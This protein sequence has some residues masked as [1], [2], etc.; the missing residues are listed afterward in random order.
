MRVWYNRT[1]SSVYAAIGLIREADTAGRFT[2]VHSNANRHTPAAR[3]VARGEERLLRLQEVEALLA[4]KAL[5][6]DACRHAVRDACTVVLDVDVDKTYMRIDGP[7]AW[8]EV[9]C[10]SGVV[11]QGKTHYHTINRDKTYDYGDTL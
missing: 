11:I 5:V 4:S 9:A 10:Q 3:L 8:I 1:F 2:I 7:R 6:V